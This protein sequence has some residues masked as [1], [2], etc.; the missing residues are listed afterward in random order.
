M[1][2]PLPARP[3]RPRVNT[4]T[5]PAAQIGRQIRTRR[6]SAGL[7]QTVLAEQVGISTRTLGSYECGERAPPLDTAAQGGALGCSVADLLD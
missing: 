3:G 6:E 5:G 4:P 7:S 1:P 2:D